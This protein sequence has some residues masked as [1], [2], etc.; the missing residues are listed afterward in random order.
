[1]ETAEI[2]ALTE[3]EINSVLSALSQSINGIKLKLGVTTKKIT[4]IK[5]IMKE[6]P[7]KAKE[8]KPR[9]D[10]LNTTVG[11]DTKELTRMIIEFNKW[12]EPTARQLQPQS[13]QA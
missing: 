8:W 11:I 10:E 2:A 12:S 3:A 4:N 6:Q 9:L 13:M 5:K 7:D 1:M